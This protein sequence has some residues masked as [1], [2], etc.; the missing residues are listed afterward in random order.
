MK[1]NQPRQGGER[2]WI[3]KESVGKGERARQT[4]QI[5]LT[6]LLQKRGEKGREEVIYSNGKQGRENV[7]WKSK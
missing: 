3:K 5:Q 2:G 1:G 6:N 7:K 4:V